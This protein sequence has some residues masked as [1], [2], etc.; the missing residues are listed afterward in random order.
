MSINSGCAV[1]LVVSIDGVAP[2]HISA[3]SMPGLIS[4]ARAGASCF[5]ATTITPS[6]TLP[7]HAS[8][9]RGVDAGKHGLFDN[10]SKTLKSEAPTF[11]AQA[12]RAGLRTARFTS[13]QPF[14]CL[15]E[16][17]AIEEKFY[18]NGGYDPSDDHRIKD[19]AQK[20]LKQRQHHLVFVYLSQVDTV[21]H[22]HGW[23]SKEYIQSLGIVDNYLS[24][25]VANLGA[26]DSVLITTDH[27]G[28]GHHHEDSRPEDLRTFM[29]MRSPKIKPASFWPNASILN[30]APSVATLAD[31][32][33]SSLW[34]T[35]SL[36][37]CEQ[38]LT[39]YLID[40]LLLTAEHS[41]GEQLN[42]LEHALQAAAEA[43]NA[44]ADESMVLACL[45]HDIGHSFG[46][47]GRW[48]LPGHAELGAQALQQI[49]N[50]SVVE[51]IRLHVAA[52][53]YLIAKDK[54]YSSK[55]SEASIA[56]LAQQGG[57][58]S[59][60]EISIFEANPYHLAAIELRRFDDAG[61]STNLNV[62]PVESYRK[63]IEAALLSPPHDANRV[64]D[65]CNCE[66]CRDINNG[67]HK[68]TADDISGW[69][70]VGECYTKSAK[71]I[72]KL[73]RPSNEQHL[74]SI[75]PS[76][77]SQSFAIETWGNDFQT[78]IEDSQFDAESHIPQAVEQIISHGIVLFK[79]LKAEKNEVLSFAKKLGFVRQTNYGS[80][81]DVI[82]EPDPINLAYTPVGLALH[83]D[84]PYREPCPGVQL[85]HC[86]KNSSE[87]GQSQFS[88]GFRAA[89]LLQ[90]RHPA[91]Y[92]IL[93][94]TPVLFRFTDDK[95]DLRNTKP[96]I[97]LDCLG[98]IVAV[99]VNHR[100]MQSESIRHSLS[101][102]FYPAYLKFVEL[103]ND[104]E[105]TINIKLHPG[106]LIMF[107]NRRVLHGRNAYRINEGR[108]LQGCYI[109]IDAIRSSHLKMTG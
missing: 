56:S 32:E 104:D 94:K 45:M 91:F 103:L 34:Q 55:L 41:Y 44:D 19:A 76:Q 102:H 8:M 72:I 108:H 99:R 85:L 40:Q 63:L 60:E 52:K 37:E 86:I 9:L 58:M 79:G 53:R 43:V 4:I 24:E 83:T 98:N 69:F 27:G 105:A 26:Q 12:T 78:L 2:R 93:T 11:L 47:A 29:V 82:A 106:E 16:E 51:P 95:V 6:I 25:L 39:N 75:E 65:N 57:P 15:F 35:Q 77:L 62:E 38:S 23:D 33:P 92:E 46:N 14:E 73:R 109:D 64:R 68:I 50:P 71:Q 89:I 30:V 22:K 90:Q 36:L 31:F 70:V 96:I 17:D 88:D 18:I 80:L 49:F 81:F 21:G 97:E 5:S 20:T 28:L 101:N 1:T 100:S 87:G 10:D 67:Q 42:M 59:D 74:C 3:E 13:W 61:K 7:A 54:T 48:G 84:N 66:K 107:D